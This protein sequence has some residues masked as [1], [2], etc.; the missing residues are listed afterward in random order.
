MLQSFQPRKTTSNGS[1]LRAVSGGCLLW[2]IL[3]CGR[4][5][6]GLPQVLFFTMCIAL[7][8]PERSFLPL[9]FS[10]GLTLHS[11]KDQTGSGALGVD[12]L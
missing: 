6:V 10:P 11:F 8:G 5:T 3:S 4:P 1:G 7:L 9:K 12:W 2:R